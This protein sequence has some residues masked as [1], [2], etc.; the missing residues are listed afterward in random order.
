M[1]L[2]FLQTIK[3]GQPAWVDLFLALSIGAP[4][5]RLAHFRGGQIHSGYF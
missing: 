1:G 2:L 4:K 3:K 5:E